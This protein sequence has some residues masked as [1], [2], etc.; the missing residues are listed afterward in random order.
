MPSIYH[1]APSYVDHWCAEI[2]VEVW[3]WWWRAPHGR[4]KQYTIKVYMR[5][6]KSYNLLTQIFDLWC[7]FLTPWPTYLYLHTHSNTLKVVEQHQRFTII[8]CLYILSIHISFKKFAVRQI[9]TWIHLRGV[10]RHL[11][12]WFGISFVYYYFLFFCFGKYKLIFFS[13]FI[14]LNWFSICIK[15]KVNED[16]T[17]KKLSSDIHAGQE[18]LC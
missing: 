13:C 3:V 7:I 15:K 6:H 11:Q 4:R 12:P 14:D 8:I 5:W 2:I 17:K 10:S 1:S 9:N 16:K 18:Q